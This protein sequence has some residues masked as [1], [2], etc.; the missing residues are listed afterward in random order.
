MAASSRARSR[1]DN[2]ANLSLVPLQCL[3]SLQARPVPMATTGRASCFRSRG[4]AARRFQQRRAYCRPA[5]AR[6]R[7]K[8]RTALSQQRRRSSPCARSSREGLTRHRTDPAIEPGRRYLRT[9]WPLLHRVAQRPHDRGPLR[10]SGRRWRARSAPGIVP[11]PR[12]FAFSADGALF[13]SSGIDPNGEGDNTVVAFARGQNRKPSRL[14]SDPELS[15]LDL[16]VAYLRQY[17]YLQRAPLRRDGCGNQRSRVWPS[18]RAPHPC[19]LSRWIGR[20]PQAPRFALWPRRDSL[21]RRPGRGHRLRFCERSMPR[22]G[23]EIPPVER[24]SRSALPP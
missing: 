24:A 10:Y 16:A 2:T 20:V 9:R 21:L 1:A 13:L 12:G 19:L 5:R 22:P 14:V 3:S 18:R 4:Q 6:R 7:S 8:E 23:R 15:P 11:F 17:S